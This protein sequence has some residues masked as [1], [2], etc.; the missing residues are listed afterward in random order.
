MGR[1]I[2]PLE[3]AAARERQQDHAGTA[4]GKTKNTSENFT[5]VMNGRALDRVAAA[6]T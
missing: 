5:E 3:S 2:E 4:P 6:G 1:A